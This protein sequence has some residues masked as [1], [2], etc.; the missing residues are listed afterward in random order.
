[1]FLTGTCSTLTNL[2]NLNPSLEFLL[3][4]TGPLSQLCG[5]P[6]TR[7]IEVDKVHKSVERQAKA[8]DKTRAATKQLLSGNETQSA[9]KTI[10][11]GAK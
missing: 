1:V 2:A 6:Q 7:S 8:F 5:N 4:L 3:G 9:L 10:L 11:G